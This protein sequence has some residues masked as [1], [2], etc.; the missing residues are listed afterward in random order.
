MKQQIFIVI[1][2]FLHKCGV[3]F[4]GRE[5]RTC[6]FFQEL[7][8][9]L[10]DKTEIEPVSVASSYSC[11]TDESVNTSSSYDACYQDYDDQLE[12]I[13]DHSVLDEIETVTEGTGG[14]PPAKR[15]KRDK[16]KCVSIPTRKTSASKRDIIDV[17][18]RM[19]QNRHELEKQ[20][21]DLLKDMQREKIT[22]MKSLMDTLKVLQTN[23]N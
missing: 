23:I 10:G 19:E 22:S 12:S 8:D 11:T 18:K 4:I 16:G 5:T 20:K 3:Y 15:P 21:M 1:I 2:Y 6:D 9:I 13:N 17:I 14:P 7:T